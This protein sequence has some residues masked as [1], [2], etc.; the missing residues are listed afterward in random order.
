MGTA[1]QSV[2]PARVNRNLLKYSLSSP[3]RDWSAYLGITRLPY[4][5]HW[6]QVLDNN[7]IWDKIISH[8]L[9]NSLLCKAN[10][11]HN[12]LQHPN[13]TMLIWSLIHPPQTF[14]T[15]QHSL[16]HWIQLVPHSWTMIVGSETVYAAHK[17]FLSPLLQLAGEDEGK[18]FTLVKYPSKCHFSYSYPVSTVIFS[19]G[20]TR[21]HLTNGEID[22]AMYS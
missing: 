3:G 7:E 12:F 21:S 14:Q 2:S 18:T 4:T 11:T 22:I 6:L 17:H 19:I 10:E 8:H 1:I 20:G 5:W 15:A 9:C 13:S 16:T